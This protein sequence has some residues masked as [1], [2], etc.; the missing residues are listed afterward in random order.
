MKAGSQAQEVDAYIVGF[1][2]EV[3]EILQKVRATIWEAAPEAEETISYQIPAFKLRGKALVYFAAF[4]NHISVYPA[5][6]GAAA[7]GELSGYKGGKGTVQ[8]PL[9]KPIPFDLISNIVTF[10]AK[11]MLAKAEE[12]R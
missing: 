3:Q 7:F 12:E 11:E 5:P 8:F 10:R 4:K 2:D 6:R 1:P 9:A